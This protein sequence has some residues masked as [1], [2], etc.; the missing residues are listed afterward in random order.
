MKTGFFNI[1][2]LATL[3]CT[4]TGNISA[5]KNK[6]KQRKDST[7]LK[8]ELTVERQYSPE[9]RD[10]SKINILPDVKNPGMEQG[11]IKFADYSVP[12]EIKP[13]VSV[14]K[15]KSYFSDLDYSKN[16][17]YLSIGANSYPG[18]GLDAG[19]K[20]LNT[21]TDLLNVYGSYKYAGGKVDYLQA[22]RNRK[23]KVND[24]F[25]GADGRHKFDSFVLNAGLNYTRSYYNYYGN[26]FSSVDTLSDKR[27]HT[28][29]FD[30]N[31]G[32]SSKEGSDLYYKLGMDY[33]YLKNSFLS[34][35]RTRGNAEHQFN[36]N[37]DLNTVL[38]SEVR[39]GVLGSVDNYFYS[40]DEGYYRGNG[41][42][43]G[44]KN[45][46]LLSGVP[47][48]AFEGGNWDAR[49][50]LRVN[51]SLGLSYRVA[52]PYIIFNFK[53]YD[54]G[55]IYVNVDG[56]VY[57][58]SLKDMY[59]ENRYVDPD[60]RLA[61][62]KS[63]FSGTAGFRTNLDRFTLD[64]FGGYSKIKNEYFFVPTHYGNMLAEYSDASLVKFGLSAKYLLQQNFDFGLSAEYNR[65]K[66]NN[67][68]MEAWNRPAF[69]ADLNLGYQVQDFPLRI[70]AVYHIET[71]RKGKDIVTDQAADMKNVNELNAK[72]SMPLSRTFSL[73]AG[74]NNLLNQSYDL[75]YG[76]PARKFSVM[77]GFSV[78]F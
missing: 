76:F 58:H 48:F 75:W 9:I 4:C 18:F 62:S 6:I 47:Y 56:G 71:G 78:K 66:L 72:V 69:Q 22:D 31:L 65:W 40:V 38:S 68:S 24:F 26:P 46:S 13:Q 3:F 61:D 1:L 70:D 11:T 67:S 2:I 50:G 12:Y 35:L 37:W 28:S 45:F 33:S 44:L 19:Y 7:S 17:G 21:E 34:D 5:Q 36:F 29:I 23:M 27:Q 15:P 63:P 43:S 77:G 14:L 32:L 51:Y 42:A 57:D 8:R 52:A 39:F 41:A 64:I 49:F 53:P 73:F 74:A 20:V 60:Y 30:F 59:E 55:T 54:K 16:R 25:I 10:A